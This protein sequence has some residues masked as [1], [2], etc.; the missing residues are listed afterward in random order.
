[1]KWV[2]GNAMIRELEMVVLT[3]D[4]PEHG[5]KK[6]DV[7]AVVHRYADG[8]AF[9]VEACILAPATEERGSRSSQGKH[10]P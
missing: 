1:V 5:L 2:G 6:G 9:E 3:R 10:L 7:G 8:V 4:V